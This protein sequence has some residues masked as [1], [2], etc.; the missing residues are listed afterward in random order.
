MKTL[1]GMLLAASLALP[2][3]AS[4]LTLDYKGF[5][6]RMDK[7]YEPDVNRMKLVFYFNHRQKHRPCRID[8]GAIL[9]HG[10]RLP[11]LVGDDQQLLLP[12]DRSLRESSAVIRVELEND[13]QC[14][15][16]MQLQAEVLD[17][18][19][20]LVEDVADIQLQMNT[21][22][23]AY[24]GVGFGWLQPEVKGVTFTLAPASK[25]QFTNPGSQPL[26]VDDKGR[27][28]LTVDEFPAGAELVFSQAP[29]S[30]SPM[31]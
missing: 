30:I 23:R 3:S 20:Y 19:R 8:D 31:M 1:T 4:A 12:F 14:D 28:T 24:A 6:D 9:S 11:L 25:A 27:L 10:K 13:N 2:F 17:K 7:L 29:H 16:A 26:P 22:M 18:R 15:F 21:L 5:Y